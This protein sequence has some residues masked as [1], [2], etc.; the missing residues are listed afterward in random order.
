MKNSS[1]ELKDELREGEIDRRFIAFE[2][3][4]LEEQADDIAMSLLMDD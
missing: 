2:D 1:D 4:T 3:K